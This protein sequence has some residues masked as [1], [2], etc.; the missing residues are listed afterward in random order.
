MSKLVKFNDK[1]LGKVSEKTILKTLP[2]ILTED[3]L[4]ACDNWRSE[5]LAKI[6]NEAI[7]YADKHLETTDEKIVISVDE[8]SL[9]GSCIGNVFIDSNAKTI[10]ETNYNHSEV[11]KAVLIHSETLYNKFNKDVPD[12]EENVSEEF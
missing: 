5:T 4:K 12:K 1:H 8:F 2:E 6:A 9:G 10:I 7:D 3:T 11:M